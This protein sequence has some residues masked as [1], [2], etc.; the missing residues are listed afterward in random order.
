MIQSRRPISESFNETMAAIQ[1]YVKDGGY[2]FH[3]VDY[4]PTHETACYHGSDSAVSPHLRNAV[5][6]ITGWDSKQYDAN[7]PDEIW[8]SSNSRLDSYI[9]ELRGVSPL[10]GAYINQADAAEPD[11]QYRIYGDNYDTLLS[12]KKQRDS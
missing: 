6:H 7:I 10:S 4:T 12:I 2:S 3:S 8:K 5:M 9:Q 11:F 1:P